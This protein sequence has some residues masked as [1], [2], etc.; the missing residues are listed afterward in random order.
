M[1]F[2][3]QQKFHAYLHDIRLLPRHCHPR[4]NCKGCLRSSGVP[5]FKD[6]VGLF[7]KACP[8][9]V[10]LCLI[11]ESARFGRE[12]LSTLA[13]R[14]FIS[15][16]AVSLQLQFPTNRTARAHHRH[17]DEK[18]TGEKIRRL[19]GRPKKRVPVAIAIS[20]YARPKL[21][22]KEVLHLTLKLRRGL[23]SLRRERAFKA[24][25]R[26]FLKYSRGAGFRL[27]QFSIQ[28]DHLHFI[29][30]ADSKPAL[31]RAMQKL[32]ISLVK[33]LAAL[34]GVAG[35]L[36]KE[37]Y[38]AHVL[39]SPIEVRR[40]ARGRGD[41]HVGSAGDLAAAGRFVL[42]PSSPRKFCASRASHVPVCVVGL[43]AY[44]SIGASA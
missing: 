34:W 16:D 31:S 36:Y 40:V 2:P 14:R 4:S 13:K 35:A 8:R 20:H 44:Q 26:S 17:V 3:L 28:N 6:V 7:C 37:R 22:K 10:P 18:V 24:I 32:G 12:L 27:T 21:G 11:V 38:H 19:P 1:L 43:R 23:P 25:E 33:R 39:K 29:A 42:Q 15:P 9:I 30:E 5:L 41:S